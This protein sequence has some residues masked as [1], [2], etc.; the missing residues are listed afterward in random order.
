MVDDESEQILN[1]WS[2]YNTQRGSPSSGVCQHLSTSA[3]VLRGTLAARPIMSRIPEIS[4]WA[5]MK[6]RLRGNQI[7]SVIK[8]S[9]SGRT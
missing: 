3:A 1:I 8:E 6:P 9:L 2:V 4:A 5:A 7:H